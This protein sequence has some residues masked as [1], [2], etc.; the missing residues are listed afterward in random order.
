MSTPNLARKVSSTNPNA[1]NQMRKQRRGFCFTIILKCKFNHAYLNILAY[2]KPVVFPT[3]LIVIHVN[4]F[5][6]ADSHCFT[7]SSVTV[8]SYKD[9]S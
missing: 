4:K 8:F 2:F 7:S 6:L 3:D 5:A 1:R 9:C